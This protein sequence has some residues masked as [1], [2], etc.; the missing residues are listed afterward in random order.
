MHRTMPKNLA[1][2]PRCGRAN[3]GNGAQGE[4]NKRF[5]ALP[6]R[7]GGPS[8]PPERRR[9]RWLLRILYSIVYSMRHTV[10]RLEF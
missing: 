7:R 6:G 9:R 1:S 2:E 4:M 10:S 5:A 3:A 8:I